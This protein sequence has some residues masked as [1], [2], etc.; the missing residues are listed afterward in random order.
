MRLSVEFAIAAAHSL[1]HSQGPCRN[2]HGHNYRILVTLEGT[3]KADGMVRDFDEVKR[4]VWD[5]VLSKVDHTNLNDSI[6]NPTA[7]NLIHWLWNELNP[8]LPGLGSLTVWETP[9]YSVTLGKQ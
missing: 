4:I 5:R 7:E 6:E 3:P 1:P 9:E 8:L 2:L